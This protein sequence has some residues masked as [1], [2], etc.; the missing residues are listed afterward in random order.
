MELLHVGVLAQPSFVFQK[1]EIGTEHHIRVRNLS[2]QYSCLLRLISND[3]IFELS[4]S[5]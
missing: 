5:A 3:E 2:R 1:Q 4:K